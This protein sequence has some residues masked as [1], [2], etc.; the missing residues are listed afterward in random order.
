MGLGLS[1]GRQ[2]AESHGGGLELLPDTGDGATFCLELPIAPASEPPKESDDQQR[3]MIV[4]V[5][6]APPQHMAIN[7]VFLSVRSSS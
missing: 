7:A 4:A 2:I 5:A 3:S 6:T 1:V